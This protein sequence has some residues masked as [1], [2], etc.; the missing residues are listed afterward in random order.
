MMLHKSL[1]TGA[2]LAAHSL[3][4][5]VDTALISVWLPGTSSLPCRSCVPTWTTATDGGASS[6]GASPP[7][8]TRHASSFTLSPAQIRVSSGLGLRMKVTTGVQG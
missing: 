3:M 8:I 1:P 6:D 7:S 2:V 5:S 4:M